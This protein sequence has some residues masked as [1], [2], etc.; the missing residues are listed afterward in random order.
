MTIEEYLTDVKR[1]YYQLSV[2]VEGKQLLAD[3][4]R[5][6]LEGE[7]SR[8]TDIRDNEGKLSKVRFATLSIP[9]ATEVDKV[10][11]DHV[12]INYGNMHLAIWPT[13][14]QHAERVE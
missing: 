4:N 11:V 6:F 12:V 8:L 3:G 2:I 7:V 14:G 5:L 9:A 1:I 10:G 13:G